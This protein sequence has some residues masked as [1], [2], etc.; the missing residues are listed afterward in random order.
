M[1]RFRA[2]RERQFH[3]DQAAG[4]LVEIEHHI[5][6]TRAPASRAEPLRELFKEA[7]AA[8]AAAPIDDRVLGDGRLVSIRFAQVLE[9]FLVQ[10]RRQCRVIRE[11]QRQRARWAVNESVAAVVGVARTAAQDEADAVV[12]VRGEWVE[13]LAAVAE[14]SAEPRQH[15]SARWRAETLQQSLPFATV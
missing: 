2:L 3:R 13:A 7:L 4:L 1:A 8:A 9:R 14:C 12:Q 5:R 15:H 6:R 10:P 11:R